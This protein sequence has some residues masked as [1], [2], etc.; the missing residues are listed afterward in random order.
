MGVYKI[1]D[2]TNWVDPCDCN[3]NVRKPD[4]SWETLDPRGCPTRYWD[5]Q[6]WCLLDCNTP[7]I[8]E[9]TEINIFFDSSGSMNSTLPPLQSMNEYLLQPC[10]IS[11]YNGDPVLYDERVKVISSSTER[12]V[13]QIGEVRNQHGRV[14]DTNVN[15]VINLVFSDESQYS[16]IG[17]PPFNPNVQTPTY[18][19]DVTSTRNAVD[20]EPYV[21]KGAMFR[22][23]STTLQSGVSQT[24][25]DFIEALF[26]DSGLYT[27]PMNLRDMFQN[28]TYNLDV[29]WG[30]TAKAILVSG[31]TTDAVDWAP[32]VYTDIQSTTTIGAGS[33][34]TFDAEVVTRSG[35]V[36]SATVT[37]VGSGYP[38]SFTFATGISGGGA[39]SCRVTVTTTAT[40]EIDP[41]SLVI[42]HEGYDY[43]V[44]QVL[45][46][47]YGG[48]ASAEITI[49][50]LAPDYEEFVLTSVNNYGDELYVAGD[51]VLT[52]APIP[53]GGTSVVRLVIQGGLGV[54]SYY[55]TQITT[56]LSTLGLQT[57]C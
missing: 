11:L 35:G 23:N 25:R 3:I 27:P 52:I 45:N 26:I 15:L 18:V 38:P 30:Q 41:L 5:G 39:L 2:G 34:M 40:G 6:N 46:I 12:S 56:A 9:N 20:T 55:L 42:D 24:Q 21:I 14:T 47:Q 33:G 51:E 54:P 48:N 57:N 17:A 10:L 13:M 49:D 36:L 50:S 22:V 29:N 32:G 37:D 16:Y 43:T 1:F 8:S 28:F 4:D 44:S 19:T 53:S 7:Q 31:S